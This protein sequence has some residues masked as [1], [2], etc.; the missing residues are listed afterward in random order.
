MAAF[1]LSPVSRAKRISDSKV[2]ALRAYP[3]LLYG[4]LSEFECAPSLTVGLLPR[5][6]T[7]EH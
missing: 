4:T 3:G 6:V 7:V 5:P 2:G 1:F